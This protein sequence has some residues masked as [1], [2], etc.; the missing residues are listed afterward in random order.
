MFADLVTDMSDLFRPGQAQSFGMGQKG[1]GIRLGVWA[2]GRLEPRPIATM[3]SNTATIPG[4]STLR[5]PVA[6]PERPALLQRNLRRA[7]VRRLPRQPDA[8]GYLLQHF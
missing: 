8:S 3:G 7:R 6:R 1:M 2:G 5:H 4:V